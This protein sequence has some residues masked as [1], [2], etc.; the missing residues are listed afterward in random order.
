MPFIE[1]LAQADGSAVRSLVALIFALIAIAAALALWLGLALGRRAG[2]LES[3][4]GRR[5]AESAARDDAVRRS[6]AVLTGQIGEQLA[7]FFPG[8]PCDPCD[9]R[10]IGKPVDFVAFPGASEGYPSEVV[11]I[12]VKTG[13]AR[14]SGPERALKDAIE[15]GRVRWVEFRLP[16]GSKRR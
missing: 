4:R 14:L 8:F 15:A 10:F 16:V 3:E 12:E 1:S 9:A 7:P 5:E 2:R 11:F 13:D 6:R